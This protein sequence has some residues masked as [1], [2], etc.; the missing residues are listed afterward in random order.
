[1]DN[2][3]HY[4]PPWIL[5]GNGFIFAFLGNKKYNLT[6]SFMT[7]ESTS[8]FEGGLAA[9]MLINYESSNVGP[10]Y[11]LLYIP[12]S[13]TY[14]NKSYKRITKIYVSS[15]TSIGE[16]IRNWAIPKEKAD[17]IWEE[18][19]DSDTTLI[20]VSKGKETFLSVSLK[21]H[22]F[23]FPITTALLP[24]KLLQKSENCYLETQLKGFGKGKLATIQKIE[25][26]ETHFPDLF[27]A[28]CLKYGLSINPFEI[29]FP[30]PGRYDFE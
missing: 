13:F 18:I 5:K 29:E 25:T 12:G 23:H 16:G 7:E 27:K 22:F 10:Y 26:N 17:F 30:I 19:P 1:M 24:Y 28:G 20:K 14:K 6:N 3:K 4:P 2:S 8:A 11:E 15:E 21:K 9:C